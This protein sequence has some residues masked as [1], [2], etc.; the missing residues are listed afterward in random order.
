[1]KRLLIP[2]AALAIAVGAACA[3]PSATGALVQR[4]ACSTTTVPPS[5]GACVHW[6]NRNPAWSYPADTEW[7]GPYSD[8]MYDLSHGNGAELLP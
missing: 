6:V 3:P 1:M 5:P 4:T 8:Y 7:Y 2:A